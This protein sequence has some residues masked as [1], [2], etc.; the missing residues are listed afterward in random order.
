M[1]GIKRGRALP[2]A[3]LVYVAANGYPYKTT[4]AAVVARWM[5]DSTMDCNSLSDRTL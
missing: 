3:A 4:F 2:T 1:A 5:P